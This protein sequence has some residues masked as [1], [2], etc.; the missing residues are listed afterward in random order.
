MSIYRYL[1][2]GGDEEVRSNVEAVSRSKIKDVKPFISVPGSV[3]SEVSAR[4]SFV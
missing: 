4:V 2:E 3:S 1:P